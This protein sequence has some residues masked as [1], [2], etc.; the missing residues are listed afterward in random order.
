MQPRITGPLHDAR[1]TGLGKRGKNGMSTLVALILI[2]VALLVPTIGFTKN[3]LKLR[4]FWILVEAA[5]LGAVYVYLQIYA[6]AT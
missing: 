3:H 1:E 5:V 2:W 4:F 6:V